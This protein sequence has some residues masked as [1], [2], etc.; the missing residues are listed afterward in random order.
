MPVAC[1]KPYHGA[2]MAKPERSGAWPKPAKVT[3]KV[4]EPTRQAQADKSVDSVDPRRELGAEHQNNLSSMAEDV[5][6][7]R[8]VAE[9]GA[10]R[11]LIK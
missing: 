7:A 2:R 5:A 11:A 8:R 9:A 1:A 6:K 3:E 10:S 4:V